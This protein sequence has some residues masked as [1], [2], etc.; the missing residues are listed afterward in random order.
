MLNSDNS[1]HCIGKGLCG[2][3][4]TTTDDKSTRVIKREDGGPG[5]SITNDYDMHLR[6]IQSMNRHPSSLPLAIP[7]CHSLNQPSDFSWWD[8]HLHRFPSGFERCRAL[9]SERIPKVPRSVSDK[10]V[11]LFLPGNPPIAAFVKNNK[12]DD[13]CLIRPYLGRRRGSRSTNTS[14]FQRFSLRNVPLHVNQMEELG[15]D[16]VAYA[17]TMA[18]ALAMMHWGA[19]VDANDFEFVLAPPRAS[20]S[21]PSFSSQYL[22]EHV[23]WILD[24][25]S[26][27]H[28]SMSE[29]GLQQ[30]C[31]AFFRN[32]SFYPRPGG[33]EAADDE[34]WKEFKARFLETGLG[35]LGEGSS[36]TDL[37]GRLMEMIEEEGH[38]KRERKDELLRLD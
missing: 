15:L 21:S 33:T 20:S 26:V 23:M 6:T 25:D 19:G 29:A 7:Q 22:G 34:L 2:S 35:I 3:I 14:R 31:A 8:E 36:Y 4:W 17:R 32:D 30:A 13:A 16:V 5:R 10:I 1:Y 38:R 24:F 18:D 9:V 27:R 11:D 28:M 12:D 37:P